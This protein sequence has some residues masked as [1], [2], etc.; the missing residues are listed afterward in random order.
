MEVGSVS[1]FFHFII[2]KEVFSMRKLLRFNLFLFLL[3]G[4]LL[5][6]GTYQEWQ[7]Q[8][9]ATDIFQM[10]E[11]WNRVEFP[12]QVMYAERERLWEMVQ[13]AKKGDDQLLF[14]SVKL[15]YAPK[16]MGEV[17][18]QRGK[19][20]IDFYGS[21]HHYLELQ[22]AIARF[23]S[24]DSANGDYEIVYHDDE[25]FN[26]FENADM[27]VN[28]LSFI[29]R[30]AQEYNKI[31]HT[32]YSEQ[33]F[34][35][36]SSELNIDSLDVDD[37]L[38]TWKL[39]ILFAFL[40]LHIYCVELQHIFSVY[41]L[42]GVSKGKFIVRYIG[43]GFALSTFVGLGVSVVLYRTL[44]W[45]M[46]IVYL[47]YWLGMACVAMG[48][49]WIMTRL[50]LSRQ[51]NHSKKLTGSM[52]GIYVLKCL[53]LIICV[54]RIGRLVQFAH[55]SLI[56]PN[57]H[58][59]ANHDIYEEYGVFYPMVVGHSVF[60]YER[61]GTEEFEDITPLYQYLEQEGMVLFDRMQFRLS[62]DG[63]E[64]SYVTV[65]PNYLAKFPLKN[66]HGDTIQIAS[67]ESRYV[68]LLPEKYVAYYE[69]VLNNVWLPE[70]MTRD[71]IDI[72]LIQNDQPLFTFD[73]EDEWLLSP[74]IV[75]VQT[76]ENAH[77]LLRVS[78]FRGSGISDP[79]KLRIHGT[80][81][82]TYKK[83]LPY[84]QQTNWD[85][86]LISFVL[87][88]DVKGTEVKNLLGNIV[89]Y[90]IHLA[91][92]LYAV[93]SLTIYTVL[94]YMAYKRRS[95]SIQLLHGVPFGYRYRFIF[96]AT[97]LLS[98]VLLANGAINF[99]DSYSWATLGILLLLDWAI[100]LGVIY[101][102]QRQ[103]IGLNVKE[104]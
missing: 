60:H 3:L 72:Y 96:G 80:T 5:F 38:N 37:T 75:Y 100:L 97:L 74:Y 12:R 86:A 62:F 41:A 35:A 59:T 91:L 9:Q 64:V 23:E 63:A 31:Y 1:S 57:H 82:A 84:L 68:L 33:D 39:T 27:F 102:Y 22:S 48:F 17:D 36:S 2:R 24:S 85:D 30:L 4:S 11:Q 21:R 90:G 46:L 98:I 78:S 10:A 101:R 40:F 66:I 6:I 20:Y 94:L 103:S 95:L 79:M 55:H 88:K 87:L 49:V 7:I 18:F 56:L 13:H 67:D 50:K 99:V 16:G 43:K 26:A 42:N 81:Q 25:S 8:E 29:S 58:V 76:L 47:G 54:Q 70:K 45:Q 19:T 89:Q 14:R 28:N 34:V 77:E 71:Q 52:I 51:L 83:M 69:S 92:E 53:V 73:P 104:R 93:L 32:N 15:Q 44:S 65:N 61:Y